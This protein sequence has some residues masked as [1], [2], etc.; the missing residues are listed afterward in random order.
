[1]LIYLSTCLCQ[2]LQQYELHSLF[3]LWLPLQ[4]YELRIPDTLAALREF[5]FMIHDQ[6][7]QQGECFCWSVK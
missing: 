3:C 1:M 7:D 4:Q 6:V 2:P 5:C